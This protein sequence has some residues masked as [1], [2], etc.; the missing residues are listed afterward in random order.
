MDAALNT[1]ENAA[2]NT[3]E[4][5]AL[6][7]VENAALNAVERQHRRAAMASDFTSYRA[8][9]HTIT[10]NCIYMNTVSVC[11]REWVRQVSARLC[12]CKSD[13]MH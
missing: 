11:A 3:V 5:A 6:N 13:V 9:R 7:A 2:L 8:V 4:N 10:N 12:G 1:V